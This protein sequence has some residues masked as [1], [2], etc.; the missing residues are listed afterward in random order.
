MLRGVKVQRPKVC[1]RARSCLKEDINTLW[2]K[3]CCTT[4]YSHL[5]TTPYS[6]TQSA[7]Y[8]HHQDT[9]EMWIWWPF[10]N[11]M[12]L[13]PSAPIRGCTRYGLGEEGGADKTLLEPK[14]MMWCQHRIGQSIQGGFWPLCVFL[15]ASS[16]F[17]IFKQCVR[18][19]VVAG[20]CW[21]AAVYFGSR[22]R[23]MWGGRADL[24]GRRQLSNKPHVNPRQEW[25]GRRGSVEDPELISIHQ[26]QDTWCQNKVGMREFFKIWFEIQTQKEQRAEGF[27]HLGSGSCRDWETRVGIMQH[28]ICA[29]PS[30]S[31]CFRAHQKLFKRILPN[32]QNECPKKTAI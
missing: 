5:C 3:Q 20:D 4:Y 2:S 28:R 9:V 22:R 15:S 21:V 1:S 23:R 16:R 10:K 7:D 11:K 32:V 26:F 24:W 31:L 8:G 27:C 25:S 18:T 17:W 12:G 30:P 13:P 14:L 19:Q 6:S 29:C